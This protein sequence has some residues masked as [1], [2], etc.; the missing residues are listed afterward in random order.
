MI[1]NPHFSYL[2]APQS[3][4]LGTIGSPGRI[5]LVGSRGP[6]AIPNF[7]VDDDAIVFA[8]IVEFALSL[9]PLSKGQEPFNGLP[10]LQ[11]YKLVRAV[12]LAEMGHVLAAN[13]SVHKHD[14]ARKDS[15]EC[16]YCEA[17]TACL[18]RAPA[19]SHLDLAEQL[20][21][22]SDRLVGAPRLDKTGSW[23][24]GKMSRPSLDSF[25]NWLGGRLTE[26]VAGGEDSPTANGDTTPHENKAFAG[27]FSHYSTISSSTTSKAPSPQPSVVN[28]NVLADAQSNFP[29][30]PGSAQ[31]VRLNP[32]VQIDRAS[33]AMEYRPIP[34]NSSPAPRIASAS[35]ATTHFSHT[36]LSNNRYP[37]ASTSNSAYQQPESESPYA[38]GT[39]WG[40]SVTEEST[41]T[42]PTATM[43]PNDRASSPSGFLSLMDG[44]PMPVVP[45]S[46]SLSRS[47]TLTTHDEDEDDDLGLGNSS[48]KH[49]ASSNDSGMG[50]GA[51]PDPKAEQISPQSRPGNVSC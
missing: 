14:N 34:R 9:A 18:S 29:R 36:R 35:A 4:V 32:H 33:S 20:R 49:K 42:T 19:G 50:N 2:L 8:E 11:P 15:I 43:F 12:N 46:A 13:R 45:T 7:H 17:I 44:S 30:R 16:R 47:S 5:A 3:G 26:F 48:G 25:G 27:P 31:A 22:L 51:V 41:T 40:S 6:T 10:H 21:E 37:Q 39:W 23:I 24:G 38:G 1:P 28:H